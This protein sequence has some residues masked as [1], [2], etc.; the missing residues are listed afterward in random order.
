MAAYA[1]KAFPGMIV[2]L[3]LAGSGLA[4][5]DAARSGSASILRSLERE[6][7]ANSDAPRLQAIRRTGIHKPPRV[8]V[9]AAAPDL[10]VAYD[11]S[12]WS[13][14]S[15]EWRQIGRASW[16]GGSRWQ[17]K[18]TSSGQRY[19]ERALTAAHATL[20]MGSRV[21]VT[22]PDSGRSVVVVVTDRPGTRSRIIDVS[23]AAA[24]ELR[25]VDR[26]VATVSITWD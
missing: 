9:V 17:G 3:L 24:T 16:Y 22:V 13:D 14:G 25:I 8:P 6:P 7:I 20:P 2:S 19:D 18:L 26:G 10:N 23:H 21:R 4:H 5:A 1:K 11:R 15:G 12:L